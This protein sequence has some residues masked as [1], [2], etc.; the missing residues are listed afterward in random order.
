[1][2][3][4]I[5]SHL[6]ISQVMLYQFC[7]RLISNKLNNIREWTI[8]SAYFHT[9]GDDE[10]EEPEIPISPRPRPMADLQ[11]KEE[12]VPLPE[13]SSFYIFGPQNKWELKINSYHNL[14]PNLSQKLLLM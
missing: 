10:E 5:P 1:M 6:Q 7:T 12:A 14:K 3:W 8:I 4:K 2:K 11:L 13:A 9:V